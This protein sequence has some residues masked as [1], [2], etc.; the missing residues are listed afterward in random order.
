MRVIHAVRE[1]NE[2]Q[3]E[4][5][6][7]IALYTEAERDAMFVRHADEAVALTNGYLDLAGL[8]HALREARADAAWVGWGFVAERPEFA[9]LCERLGIVFVGPEAAVMRL[10]GDKV[11]AKRMAEE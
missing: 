7:V 4:S 5:I 11:A 1:L 10:V 9:E 8:E 6:R 2:Q 3:A